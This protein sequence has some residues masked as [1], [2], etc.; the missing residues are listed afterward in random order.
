MTMKENNYIIRLE[1][2]RLG[3]GKVV[4][5]NPDHISIPRGITIVYGENGSGKTTFGTIIEKGRYAYGNRISFSD[6]IEKVKM[7]SFTDIHS[8]SGMEAHYYV[9]RLEATMNDMVPTVGMIMGDKV[10]NPLWIGLCETF[11]LQNIIDKRINF[12]SSGEL[13]W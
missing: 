13:R 3:Y 11:D 12:L 2:D 4:L 7:L 6:G 10:C 9:Q 5:S 8:L 1:S